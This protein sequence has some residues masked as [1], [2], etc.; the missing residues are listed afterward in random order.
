MSLFSFWLLKSGDQSKSL[1]KLGLLDCSSQIY[2][3]WILIISKTQQL[4]WNFFRKVSMAT[5]KIW[6][7][8]YNLIPDL[9]NFSCLKI[10]TI[11][12]K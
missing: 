3:F 7:A 4:T 8:C 9:K 1:N 12:S 2:K 10:V 6:Q 11:I 5:K